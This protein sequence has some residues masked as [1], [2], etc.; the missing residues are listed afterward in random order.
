VLPTLPKQQLVFIF[1]ISPGDLLYLMLKPCKSR[2]V[3][4]S[5]FIK[6]AEMSPSVSNIRVILSGSFY[7]RTTEDVLL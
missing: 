2:K 7:P 6:A 4:R 3:H 1:G 5:P